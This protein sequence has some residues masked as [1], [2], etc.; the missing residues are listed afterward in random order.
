MTSLMS[1]FIN[2]TSSSC[3]LLYTIFFFFRRSFFFLEDGNSSKEKTLVTK[4]EAK[5]PKKPKPLPVPP[6]PILFGL[7]NSKFRLNNTSCLS[8]ILKLAS[9]KTAPLNS[10]FTANVNKNS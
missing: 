8:K 10:R 7:P 1:H 2:Q 3:A 4:V 9:V 5:L 6:L